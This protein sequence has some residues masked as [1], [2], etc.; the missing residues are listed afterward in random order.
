MRLGERGRRDPPEAEVRWGE[1]LFSPE[2]ELGE[3]LKEV[4]TVP[5][6]RRHSAKTRTSLENLDHEKAG[7]QACILA[8]GRE[9]L[10]NPD[11][12]EELQERMGNRVLM[13][14]QSLG[15]V[16][17]D[18]MVT[19]SKSIEEQEGGVDTTFTPVNA[20]HNVAAVVL[21]PGSCLL[22]RFVDKHVHLVFPDLLGREALAH[23]PAQGE[24]REIAFGHGTTVR[25]QLWVIQPVVQIQRIERRRD[26]HPVNAGNIRAKLLPI[27]IL[28]MGDRV[29][30]PWLF[31]VHF[32][33]VGGDFAGLVVDSVSK[34]WTLR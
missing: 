6:L 17:T 3:E 31:P 12:D 34:S 18:F 30:P 2:N 9:F 24:E 20:S 21:L 19:T 28:D 23:R 16:A 26:W 5:I 32:E 15:S 8:Q 14:R 22:R 25:E 29:S 27:V 33:H 1:S 4:V 10:I 7:L 11:Q 13:L